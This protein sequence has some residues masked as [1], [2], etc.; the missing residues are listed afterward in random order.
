MFSSARIFR[1]IFLM[2]ASPV[3]AADGKLIGTAGLSQVE[4]SGGGGLVPWATLSGYDSRDEFSI[5]T[6]VTQVSLDDYRLNVTAASLSIYDK[7]EISI[8]KQNFALKSL[9]GEIRQDIYGIKYRLY[10]D[11]VYSKT[12]QFSLGMQHKVLKDR[13][14]ASLVGAEDTKGTDLYLSATKVHLGALVGYNIVWNL[15]ARATK[16]NE[17]GLLGFEG[18]ENSSYEL[19]L[20]GSV[21][22]FLSRK[23]AI[24]FEYRQKPDN[25]G[26]EED[27]W[28]DVFITYLPSKDFSLTLAW[29]E[30]GNIAGSDNQAG[31][32]ISFQG[33]LW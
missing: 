21:G 28:K 31:M 30:L 20:E 29:A 7:I 11:L 14:I 12:P 13:A 33:Q 6:A 15:T 3:I 2:L 18:T 8:A 32:Y 27:D 16:A 4:G 19:M 24:G 10:G 22:V 1:C 17:L 25:L 9:G 26:L 5:S 23:V